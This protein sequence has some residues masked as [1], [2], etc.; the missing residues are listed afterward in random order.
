VFVDPADVSA[1]SDRGRYSARRKTAVVLRLLRGEDIDVLSRELA[2]M[3]ATVSGWRDQFLAAGQ[4]GL[5]TRQQDERDEEV[6]RLM[7]K[8]GEIT[9]EN[10]L[11]R[12]ETRRLKGNL[13]LAFR[14]SRQ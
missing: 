14:R 11:L 2:V 3:A 10:E 1:S 5:K 9:M 8:V 13:P 12:E 6:R 4:A 7:A